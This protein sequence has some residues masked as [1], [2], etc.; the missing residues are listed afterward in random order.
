[1][2][3]TIGIGKSPNPAISPARA[4]NSPGIS[5][6]RIL[7]GEVLS[8]PPWDFPGRFLGRITRRGDFPGRSVLFGQIFPNL[9]LPGLLGGGAV[10][11]FSNTAWDITIY[12]I[13]LMEGV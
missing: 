1:M 5:T 6:A 7:H 10:W 9:A 3:P 11:S 2:V 12:A 13:A 4:T 8:A